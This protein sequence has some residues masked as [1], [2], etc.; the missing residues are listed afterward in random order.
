MFKS[1]SLIIILIISGCSMSN[2]EIIKEHEKCKNAGMSTIVNNNGYS[3][4]VKSVVCMPPK[5][6]LIINNGED[7]NETTSKN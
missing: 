2:D 6:N 5:N 4:N 1:L 7:N 3:N